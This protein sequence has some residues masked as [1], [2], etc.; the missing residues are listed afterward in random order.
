MLLWKAKLFCG[1]DKSITTPTVD[2]SDCKNRYSIQ[3]L[4]FWY[5]YYR[6]TRL[7]VGTSLSHWC[8]MI[9][10]QLEIVGM[11]CSFYLPMRYFSGSMSL[12]LWTTQTFLYMY[13]VLETAA[14]KTL[15]SLCWQTQPKQSE[16]LRYSSVWEPCWK[17][18]LK[19]LPAES[20]IAAQSYMLYTIGK[21]SAPGSLITQHHGPK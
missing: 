8:Y 2:Q 3:Y 12:P 14:A 17:P 13:I 5:C 18:C 4:L 11:N 7:N 19:A 10:L 1:Y 6:K 21:L 9:V 15:P 20:Y 16:S